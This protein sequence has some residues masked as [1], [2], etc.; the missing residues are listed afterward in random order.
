MVIFTEEITGKLVLERGERKVSKYLEQLL[1]KETHCRRI[2][3]YFLF[4]APEYLVHI[5]CQVKYDVVG[6]EHQVLL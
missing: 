4:N 1:K 3:L 2:L 5:V 6:V